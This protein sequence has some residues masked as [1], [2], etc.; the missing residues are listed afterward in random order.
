MVDEITDRT[1]VAVDAVDGR[2]HYAEL[3]RLRPADIP[4]RGTLVALAGDM[5]P[6]KPTAAPR[7][8][9]L[10]PVEIAHQAQYEG[11]T[12]IDQALLAKWRPDPE[13]SGFG[14]ELRGAFAARLQWLRQRQ[15]IE[16]TDSAD[17]GVP[18]ADMM[19]SLRQLE[20]QRLTTA[21]SRE[22]GAAYVPHAA[23]TSIDGIYDR[24]IVTPTGTLAVIR[25][26]DTFSLAPWKTALE[27]LR[28]QAVVGVVG[29]NR[30]TWTLDR[31]R[32]LPG[33]S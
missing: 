17:A 26:Q 31:G 16:R 25:R 2:V 8:Q 18:K 27:P 21:L 20:T 14:T 6:S 23:G 33:R 11:P 29:P 4:A 30:V 5:V 22:L 15:L 12:W 1:W 13:V 19:R 3:G 9:L 32:V 10:S 7:L 24:P 28:G